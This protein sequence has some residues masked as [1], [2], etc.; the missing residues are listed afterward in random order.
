MSNNLDKIIFKNKK[1]SDLLEEI[2][3]N[4][5]K[6]QGQI[7]SLIAELKP[8]VKELG[9]ATLVVPL[10]KDYLDMGVKNDEH[11]I[12]LAGI[13]QRIEEKSNNKNGGEVGFNLTEEEKKQIEEEI[14]KLDNKNE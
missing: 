13:I 4:Q 6:T 3:N 8:L 14:N 12:K 1:F 9:D 7:S 5:K 10:I 11:L 2:Y